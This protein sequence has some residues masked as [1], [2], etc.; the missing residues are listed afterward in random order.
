M[1]NV[2]PLRFLLPF[3]LSALLPLAGTAASAGNDKGIFWRAD[4][5]EQRIYLL[6]SIHLA[7]ADFYPLREQI[8]RAYRESDTLVVEA[9]IIAAESDVAL[10]QQIMSESLYG[11]DQ[12]LRDHLS[13]QVFAKLQA[14]LRSRKLPEALFIRQR[15][16]IAMISI[17]L[18]EMQ[19]RGL[20]PSLGIDRHFLKQARD[21]GK[22]IV[23]LEGI[24]HQLRLLNSLEKPDLLL[25]QTLE[26]LQEI[27][28]L[29]PQLVS[30]WK[31]GNS[32]NLYKLMIADGLK[33]HPEYLPLYETLFFHRNRD[34]ADKLVQH[35]KKGAPLFVVV[36]AGHLVGEKS[37]VTL[38]QQNGFSVKQI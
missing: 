3:L 19:A 11:P 16:A 23:E 30:N 22:Q 6:G 7:T 38:L 2:Q 28:T 12:S 35:S 20:D 18:M 29:L 9:D 10:Q 5:G 21:S 4:K 33:E 27:D 36:G 32:A 25:Q 26:Q 34:M 37:V 8:Q 13:P 31:A 17:S 1:L 14:W 24:L 15:P